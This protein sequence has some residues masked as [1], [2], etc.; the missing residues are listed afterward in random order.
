M[1]IFKDLLDT[2]RTKRQK[3]MVTG[4]S[5]LLGSK[6]VPLLDTKYEVYP[7]YNLNQINHKNAIKVN[8]LDFNQIEKNIIDINPDVIIHAAAMSNVDQCERDPELAFQINTDS[9]INILKSAL[10]TGSHLV[11]LS[12]D[13]VFN[14]EKGDYTEY[15]QP[16]PINVYGKT[17]YMSEQAITGSGIEYTIVRTSVMYG[18]TAGSG[19]INYV[20]W[21]IKR[22]TENNPI[23]IITDQTVSPTYNMNLANMLAETVERKLTGIYNLS[24]ATQINRYD[25]TQKIVE[26]FEL[27]PELVIPTTTDKML[28]TAK[29]PKNSSLNTKK[30]RNTLCNKPQKLEYSLQQLKNELLKT[31]LI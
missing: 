9:T 5:G 2:E 30:A 1:S 23:S 14:G 16:D 22:L 3:I 25:F 26:Q 15:D 31:I 7:I 28:W 17:K 27:N 19:K 11:F 18:S 8:I 4:G 13:Y 12:T 29:R 21:V 24:G 6:L 10:N 20:L